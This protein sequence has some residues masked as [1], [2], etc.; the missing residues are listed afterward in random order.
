MWFGFPFHCQ[1]ILYFICHGFNKDLEILFITNFRKYEI[2]SGF[3]QKKMVCCSCSVIF[4]FF[5]SPSNS[6]N[7]YFLLLWLSFFL[8]LILSFC[9]CRWAMMKFVAVH[10]SLMYLR[11]LASIAVFRNANVTN[12]IVGKNYEEHK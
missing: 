6:H 2:N 7:Q 3:V 8:A 10:S 5:F 1:K 4:L 9:I 11:K 12:T